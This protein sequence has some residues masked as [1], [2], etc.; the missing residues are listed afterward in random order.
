MVLIR[1]SS[2]GLIKNT[3]GIIKTAESSTSVLSNDWINV[4]CQ[5]Q[6]PVKVPSSPHS[7]LVP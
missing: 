1:R 6:L 2:A 7:K 3:N 5:L 4:F